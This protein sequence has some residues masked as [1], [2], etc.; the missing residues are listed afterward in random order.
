MRL[1]GVLALESTFAA[2]SVALFA[3]DPA[4]LPASD[5]GATGSGGTAT[6]CP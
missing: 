5:C 2:G 1:L 3:F 4:C 6:C